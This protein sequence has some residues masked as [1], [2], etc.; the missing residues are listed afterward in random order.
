MFKRFFSIKYRLLTEKPVK[1]VPTGRHLAKVLS[2]YDG[3]TITVSLIYCD[4]AF[5]YNV[6]IYGID[7]PEL[8]YKGLNKNT[9]NLDDQNIKELRTMRDK[10]LLARDKLIEL[11]GDNP[12]VFLDCKG[13]EKYGRLLAEVWPSVSNGCFGGLQPGKETFADTLIKQGY[14][15]PYFGKG[16]DCVPSP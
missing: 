1:T 4:I 15:V 10:G 2:I 11:I 7:T 3:D 6:R 9:E 16:R 5:E 8:K 13:K 14:G 12:F